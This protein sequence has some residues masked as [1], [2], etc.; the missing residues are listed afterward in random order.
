MV[1]NNPK[2]LNL[3]KKLCLLKLPS[4]FTIRCFTGSLVSISKDRIKCVLLKKLNIFKL[5]QHLSI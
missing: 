2:F 5:D 3:F 1:K 4:A